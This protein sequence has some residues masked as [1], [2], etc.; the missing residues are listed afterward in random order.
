[1]A[2]LVEDDAYLSKRRSV[3][4]VY[5]ER[6]GSRAERNNKFPQKTITTIKAKNNNSKNPKRKPSK[7]F[8]RLGVLFIFC[9]FFFI[10]EILYCVPREIRPS[11]AIPITDF[12]S[13]GLFSLMSVHFDV[14]TE[15]QPVKKKG[16]KVML[17]MRIS[18]HVYMNTAMV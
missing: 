1:M 3:E 10:I 6:S 9:V 17:A 8:L 15:V 2:F 7:D 13:S 14:Q 11:Y 18:L 16:R 12:S 4:M 5:H